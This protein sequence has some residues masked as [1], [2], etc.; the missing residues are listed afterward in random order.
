MWG[1]TVESIPTEE[2]GAAETGTDSNPH[3]LPLS[4]AV[5]EKVLELCEERRKGW[6]E[7][8]F[9]KCI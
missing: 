8:V 6:E 2:E 7:S 4:T 1:R 5:G 3:S 9:K